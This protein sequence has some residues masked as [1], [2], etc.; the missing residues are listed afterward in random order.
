MSPVIDQ[1][2]LTFGYKDFWQTPARRA[3]RME[4]RRGLYLGP[5]GVP[6]GPIGQRL[7]AG[8]TSGVDQVR[9]VAAFNRVIAPVSALKSA[10]QAIFHFGHVATQ[11]PAPGT[12]NA[13]TAAK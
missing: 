12:A 2:P 3:W 5:V 9:K 1:A 7:G 8:I 6:L 11:T 13:W 4:A 10:T